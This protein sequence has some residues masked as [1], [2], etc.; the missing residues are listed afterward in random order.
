[1]Q[2]PQ[3]RTIGVIG[4][5]LFRINDLIALS[6]GPRRI[7]NRRGCDGIDPVDNSGALTRRFCLALAKEAAGMPLPTHRCAQ[8]E[9][10]HFLISCRLSPGLVS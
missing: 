7:D 6:M 4:R 2:L 3:V 8:A 1:M 5:Q 10:Y 9:W